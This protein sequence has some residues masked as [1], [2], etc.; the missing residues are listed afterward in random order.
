MERLNLELRLTS[1]GCH[2]NRFQLVENT[3]KIAKTII[4]KVIILENKMFK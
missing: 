4:E 3:K 2:N 1:K